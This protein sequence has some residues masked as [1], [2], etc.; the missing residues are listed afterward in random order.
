MSFRWRRLD[1]NIAYTGRELRSGWVHCQTGLHGDAAVVFAGPC[2]VATEDLVDLDDRRAGE[3]IV[4]ARMLHVIVEHGDCP[5]RVG[6]LRQRLLVCI[7][8][9]VLRSR[10]VEVRRSG[11]D[12]YVADRKLTVSIAAPAATACL[13]HLGINDDASGAPVPAVGLSEL[14]VDLRELADD[15][16]RNYE[17]ELRSAAH[18]ETKV[19]ELGEDQ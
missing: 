10:G 6:V 9:E 17:Q 11:D 19:C 2:N 12:V 18:A 4:A 1:E 8:C 13:I 16:L 14:G 5:I 7:L 3:T 15:V